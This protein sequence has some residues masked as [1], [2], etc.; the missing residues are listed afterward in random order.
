MPTIL[1]SAVA[2]V[3]GTLLVGLAAQAQSPDT[4]R[5]SGPAAGQAQGRIGGAGRGGPP[6]GPAM[7]LT[8]TAWPDGGEIPARHVGGQTGLSPA[9]S[10]SSV[11][12]G[13]VEFVLIMTDPD[14]TV[15]IGSATGDVLHWLVAKIPG[16]TTSLPEGA[17]SANSALLPV[18]AR[19]I[20]AYRGPGAP[21]TEPLHHYTFT[22]YALNAPLELAPDANR[23][24]VMAAMDGKVTARGI[25]TGRF[26][27]AA[28]PVPGE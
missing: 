22:V 7:L 10:W 11:P 1:S 27:Q 9:L 18:G 2:F 4:P 21:A 25:F 24:A 17:G 23:A 8:S 19:Q 15:P 13:T 3:V 28:P 20:A 12:L 16:T 5:G 6:R 26:R 14:T